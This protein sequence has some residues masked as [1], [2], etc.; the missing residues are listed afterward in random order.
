MPSNPCVG[1][2]V[3]DGGGH[4]LDGSFLGETAARLAVPGGLQ[5]G[6]AEDGARGGG[7][8][9]L[10]GPRVQH[11]HLHPARAH[12][13]HERMVVGGGCCFGGG[14]EC[15][16]RGGHQRGHGAQQH[17]LAS[18]SCKHL[19]HHSLRQ[20]Y[21]CDAVEGNNL[22]ENFLGSVLSSGSLGRSGSVHHNL[23]SSFRKRIVG[24]GHGLLQYLRRSCNVKGQY[25][26]AI[27]TAQLPCHLLQ[28]VFVTSSKDD[29]C[30][31]SVQ[32]DR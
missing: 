7:V 9:A 4:Q 13:A 30:T 3:I 19:S 20:G 12:L 21:G 28:S 8:R 31:T 23:Q 32:C 1:H 11:R 24:L 25:M 5:A 29:K 15:L 16:P 2:L 27:C 10:H 22:G 14:V 6:G 18:P 17:E 26:H